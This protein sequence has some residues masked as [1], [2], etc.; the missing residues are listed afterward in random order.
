MA[1]GALDAASGGWDERLHSGGVQPSGELLGL[2]FLQPSNNTVHRSE[3]RRAQFTISWMAQQL[4]RVAELLESPPAA[5]SWLAGHEWAGRGCR[6]PMCILCA[7]GILR[8][9]QSDDWRLLS[10]K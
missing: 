8:I 4:W 2:G 3:D 7:F 5:L 10:W 1:S 9:E 6:R